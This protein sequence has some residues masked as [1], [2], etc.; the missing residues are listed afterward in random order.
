VRPIRPGNTH[1][2]ALPGGGV[3]DRR[4]GRAKP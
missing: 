3:R 2:I 4:A 1:R